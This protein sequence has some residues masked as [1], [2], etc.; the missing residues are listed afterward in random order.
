M[1]VRTLAAAVAL[2]GVAVLGG[3]PLAAADG[4]ARDPFSAIRGHQSP[5]AETTCLADIS[6]I[7]D[8]GPLRCAQQ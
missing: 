2:A 3:A 1:R 8:P 7:V 6:F 5:P 4:E